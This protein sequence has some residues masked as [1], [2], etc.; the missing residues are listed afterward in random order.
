MKRWCLTLKKKNRNHS[1]CDI[2]LSLQ[3][4]KDIIELSFR[5]K[6]GHTPSALSMSD[7]L[8]VLFKHYIQPLKDRIL[9]GKP[10]GAQA[11]YSIFYRLGLI[12]SPFDKYCKDGLKEWSYI[13][14]RAHPFIDFIDDT[15][16]NAL[17]VACG[18]AFANK[19][20]KVFI[21]ISDGYLQEGTAWEGIAFAGFHRLSNLILAVDNNGMQA[22]GF[23]KQI[24]S[25]EPIVDKFESFGWDAYR[26]D[27][28]NQNNLTLG[29]ANAM[30]N[31]HEKPL[32]FIF[33]TIKGCG[34]S[35]ME[36]NAKWHYETID[37]VHMHLANQELEK[38]Y[39]EK[40]YG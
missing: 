21:N 17:S 20:K 1:N 32:A 29:I 18:M 28:I 31:I 12:E 23:T 34:V 38:F 5:S 4:K 13:L 25:L 30:C 36:N 22:T 11:Y 15:M 7:Y 16:G 9:L 2:E 39:K 14:D 37:E 33:D 3:I 35:F 24:L 26:I 40:Y 27:G 19:S 6:A 10:Y 8:L